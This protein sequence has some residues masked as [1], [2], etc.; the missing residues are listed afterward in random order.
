MKNSSLQDQL[1]NAG[2]VNKNKVKQ[3]RAEKRKQSKKQ[4]KNKI[5]VVDVT[6]QLVLEAKAKMIEKDKQLN[7]QRNKDAEKKQI[8]DQIQQLINLNKLANDDEGEA[9]NFTDKNKV[10]VIYINE[11]TR[12]KIIAGK[13]AIVK[14]KKSYDVVPVEVAEKIKQRD[15]NVVKVLFTDKTEGVN[16][17]NDY[18]EYQIPDDLMW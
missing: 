4:Q 6:K 10:K 17:D 15:E 9:Y 14:S 1:L 3:V 5:E 13:L 8:A 16:E 11:E 2:L 18:Q 7:E 12:N